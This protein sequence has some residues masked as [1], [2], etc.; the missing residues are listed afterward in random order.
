MRHK[1]QIGTKQF[2]STHILHHIIIITDKNPTLPSSQFENCKGVSRFD[3]R[4]NKGMQL[5]VVCNNLSSIYTHIS[6]I[7]IVHLITLKQ[8]CQHSYPVLCRNFFK[9]INR[10]AVRNWLRDFVHLRVRKVSGKSIACHRTF[11]KSYCIGPFS[12]RFC[13][14]FFNNSQVI[15][16]IAGAIF[17]LDCGYFYT[18]HS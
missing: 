3:S 10:R 9:P 7:N 14:K 11:V 18:L 16:F 2:G 17:K 12:C 4:I 1:N 8:T 6:L 15:L 13:S 5:S